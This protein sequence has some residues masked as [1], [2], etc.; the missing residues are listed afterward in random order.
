MFRR[1]GERARLDHRGT[2]EV[3][4]EDG[5][6]VGLEDALGRHCGGLNQRN[7]GE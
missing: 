7:A 6:A 4:V 3:V 2:S 5:L 1:L